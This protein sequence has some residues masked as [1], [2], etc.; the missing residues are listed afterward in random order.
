MNII[1]DFD[2]AQAFASSW[3]NLRAGS[4]YTK[5]QV[6]DW[7]LPLEKND[8]EG[9]TILELGCGNA[10]L[11]LHILDW[12]PETLVEWMLFVGKLDF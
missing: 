3:N 5:D 1:Q 8:I 12:A 4:I 6:C 11:L 10:S 2:T 9:K 7:F